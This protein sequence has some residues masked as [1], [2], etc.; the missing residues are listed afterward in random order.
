MRSVKIGN[1][2][3]LDN[4]GNNVR[5]FQEYFEAKEISQKEQIIFESMEEYEDSICCDCYDFS[6]EQI[7]DFLKSIDTHSINSLQKYVS[8]FHGYTV[9]CIE[10]N[11]SDS[12]KN[13][14]RK[15]KKE[16]IRNC[17]NVNKLQKKR[18]SK[19]TVIELCRS[20]NNACDRFI[21]MASFEGFT[22]DEIIELRD[23][24]FDFKNNTIRHPDMKRVFEYPIE[25]MLY[26][27]LSLSENNYD[28]GRLTF[29]LFDVD[30]NNRAIIKNMEGGKEINRQAVLARYLRK[31]QQLGKN[32]SDC[33][34]K[35]LYI[36]GFIRA[37][38]QNKDGM[39]VD[40]FIK[41]NNDNYKEVLARYGKAGVSA[42]TIRKTYYNITGGKEL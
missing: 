18:I 39:S 13:E 6:V 16:D 30:P 4:G 27:S 25:L 23:Y 3:D 19:Q 40:E 31:I 17:I 41:S 5:H 15:I 8:L 33:N 35:N 37:L 21:A 10:N 2:S 36:S 34:P 24:H 11:Y 1:S 38:E 14:W 20:L 9:F 29:N 7:L 32:F 42:F 28:S 12:N 26:G 22:L